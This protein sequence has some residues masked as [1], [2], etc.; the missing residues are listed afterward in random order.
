MRPPRPKP[1]GPLDELQLGLPRPP[2]LASVADKYAV[3][4]SMSHQFTNHIA[5]T[6]VTMTGSNNQP[7]QDREAHPND[8][9]GPGAILNHERPAVH[10]VPPSV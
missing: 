5:G 2:R 9:P 3:I 8:F 6:Y 1:A 10:G 7:D 4:R